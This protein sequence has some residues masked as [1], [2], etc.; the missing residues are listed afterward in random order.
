MSEDKIMN[1]NIDGTDADVEDV[2]VAD[3][4]S[5]ESA[6]RGGVFSRRGVSLDITKLVYLSVFTAL[7]VVLQIVANITG[8]LLPVPITLTLVPI[9]LGSAL[10]DKWSG[11]WLGLVFAVTVLFSGASEPFFTINPFGTVVTV[12]IKGVAAGLVAGLV[13]HILQKKNRYLAV[14]CAGAVAPIVNTGIFVAA[15]FI[16]FR[17]F[18]YSLAAG[19][20]IFTFVITAFVGI[21]FLIELG[22]NIMLAPVVL[23]LINIKKKI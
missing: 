4:G 6:A 19:E 10:C 16:F 20:H 13:Y 12:I 18:V 1:E 22:I 7:V 17:D 21:N 14:I 15:S 5:S 9:V 11:A 2:R 8:A 23:R 3:N